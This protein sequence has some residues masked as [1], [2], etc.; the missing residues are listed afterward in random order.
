MTRLA[1]VLM[2]AVLCVFVL[3]CPGL[4]PP[5]VQQAATGGSGS[6][7]DDGGG[8]TGDTDV[9]DQ[10]GTGDTGDGDGAGGTDG[11][12][13]DVS[14]VALSYKGSVSGSV[15]TS[16]STD[17]KA[18]PES[19]R[20]YFPLMLGTAATAWLT[21]M[22]G[23]P[24]LDAMGEEYPTY[25]IAGD[26]TFELGELPVGVDVMLHVDLDG[27][28]EADLVTIIQIP[29]DEGGAG[30]GTLDD[31]V[32][33]PLTTL[34]VAKLEAIMARLGIDP[35]DLG[36]SACGLVEQ[37][38][39]AFANLYDAAGILAE[40]DF[41]DIANMTDAELA[42]LFE[43]LIPSSARQGMNMAEHRFAL[44]VAEDVED[45]VLAVARLLLEG[46]MMVADEPG[47][48][49]LSS[50]D[51]LP[52][53]AGLTF[54]EFF[55]QMMGESSAGKEGSPPEFAQAIPD[56]GFIVY[57]HTAPE[58]DRNFAHEEGHEP[59]GK[60]PMFSEYAL[61]QM[62][63]AYLEGLTISLID[64]HTIL[65]NPSRGLGVRLM[66]TKFD[67]PMGPPVDVFPTANG[68]GV[69]RNVWGPGGLMDQIME[70]TGFD[71]SPES[72]AL[73]EAAVRALLVDF[74]E[75]TVP[76]T[77]EGLF[78]GILMNRVPSADQFAR[79]IRDQRVHIPWSMSGPSLLYVVATADSWMDPSAVAVTVDVVTDANGDVTGVTYNSAGTG[80][81]YV[82]YGWPVANGHMV[83][84]FQ[85][86]NGRLLHNYDGQV[87]H[88]NLLG[89]GIFAPVGGESFYDAFS[90]THSEW[91]LAP[92]LMVANH[93]FDPSL[94]P[95]PET[96]P[97]DFKIMV[98]MGGYEWDA[99]P[100]R[101]L[102]D[103]VTGIATYD[104]MG[105]W[106]LMADEGTWTDGLFTLI[107]DTGD[108]LEET[109]GDWESRVRISPDDVVGLE[110]VQE[111]FT[112]L[113]GIDAPNPAYDPDGAPYYD[114]INENG[115][116]DAGEPFFS[117]RHY[118]W[119]PNDWHSTFV[120][121][122]YRRVDTNGFPDPEQI[123]WD[124][125][126]PRMLDGTLLK[127]R[128]YRPRLNGWK[129]GHPGLTVNLLMMFSPPEF[130]NG[131][132]ALSGDTR[133][134]SLMT[135][136]MVTLVMDSMHT[137][138]AEIDFDGPGP[139]PAHF[140]RVPAYFFTP[141]VGDPVQ[142]L[143]DGFQDLAK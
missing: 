125:D 6:Q 86:Q 1:T 122:Y 44:S 95:D 36:M 67:D 139:Q 22:D 119:D 109:P 33:D 12:D 45:V 46:G 130:F 103:E 68:Q 17:G 19:G 54:E 105:Q 81:F 28:G 61:H 84:L 21:D 136:A 59:G 87:V 94:P 10:D 55:D 117:E 77:M 24:L 63:E 121:Q 123:N 47:G 14:D 91:P 142:M 128:N 65:T 110:L 113:Y 62:A 114:D 38:R 83:E 30:T 23:N 71:P 93:E 16:T 124:S 41:E 58:V 126:V 90:E 107:M 25:P 99:P 43:T 112:W 11:A 53:V 97:P 39:D 108:A 104:A 70:L 75:G 48:V 127:A 118:L 80:D 82:S 120:E 52:N 85:R 143:I 26:G 66:Y 111:A 138:R 89:R 31:T 116:E 50:L 18:D 27:D 106:Y 56:S 40:I 101:V 29:E 34:V 15:A 51:D 35:T 100:V 98:L 129:F 37:T 60:G 13:G 76:P 74:L 78:E 137:V 4:A 64:L 7:T 140:E 69:E 20:K 79:Y 134:N 133:I 42:E 2:S 96:N 92:E 135:L 57:V 88:L 141:P 5:A 32:V 115:V 3:G 9:G 8:Q 49:D 72:W 102:Y 73:H 132:H 131:R